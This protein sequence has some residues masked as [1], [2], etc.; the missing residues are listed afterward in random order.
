M[1]IKMSQNWFY[2]GLARDVT[3]QA[4]VS[5]PPCWTAR[6]SWDVHRPPRA[7]CV[8]KCSSTTM[9]I[10]CSAYNCENRQGPNGLSFHRFPK[11]PE[12][13]KRWISAV[14]RK[15]W[16]PSKYSRICSAHFVGG[17]C[18]LILVGQTTCIQLV[19]W[20]LPF[21]GNWI[22]AGGPFHYLKGGAAYT[23]TFI[24]HMVIPIFLS[25]LR[26]FMDWFNFWLC[27]LHSG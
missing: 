17:E 7:H 19:Y 12:L 23:I 1:E 18:C 16:Q 27:H 6:G 4:P 5:R 22:I 8:Y 24:W 10:S 3:G 26:V 14:N 2:S 21:L 25:I 11:D 15:D 20:T 9:V 13:R